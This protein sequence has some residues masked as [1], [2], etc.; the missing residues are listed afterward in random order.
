MDASKLNKSDGGANVQK[1]RD[2]Y[3]D[4]VVDGVTTRVIQKMQNAEGVQLGLQ[5]ILRARGKDCMR[6][7][8]GQYSGNQSNKLCNSCKNHT[9]KE[10]PNATCCMFGVL[11]NESDFKEQKSWLSE[12]VQYYPGCN[13]F[14]YPKFHCELNFVEMVWGWT[15]LHHRQGCTYTYKGLKEGLPI[16]LDEKLPIAYVR[17]AFDLLMIYEWISCWSHWCCA[18]VRSDEIQE[19]SAFMSIN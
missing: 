15:K 1:M 16:T 6:L 18:G 9:E 2:G 19:P 4:S 7:P 8:D 3:Y 17:R 10:D 11:S 14:F 12:T 5:S 13:I